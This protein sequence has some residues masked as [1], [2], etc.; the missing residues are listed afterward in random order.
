LQR[1][2]VD[3][4]IRF[5]YGEDDGLCSVPVR[6]EW[7]TPVMSPELAD[8]HP[9]VESLTNA[10][11]IFDESID[12]LRPIPDWSAWFRAVGVAFNPEHGAR[13][14]NADHAVDAAVAGVGV[15]LARRSMILKDLEEGRLVA[16][17]KTAIETTGRFRFLCLPGTETR[18]QI[19]AFRN[20][21]IS[22]ID[23]TAHISDAFR[24]VPLEDIPPP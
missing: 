20:W 19:A 8:Q 6:R 17:F 3:V 16:P 15:A 2:D 18:P 12:F 24:I 13:F 9:T 5:G 4:A 10:P 14:S 21:F 11:L 23:K 1:D 7:L 22:E